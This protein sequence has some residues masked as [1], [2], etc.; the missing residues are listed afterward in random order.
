MTI[1]KIIGWILLVIGLAVI[2][3]TS[4]SSY[5]IF[6]ARAEAPEVFKMEEETPSQEDDKEISSQ[7]SPEELQKEMKK[8]VE[9]QI[10]EMIPSEFL[11][12]LLNLISWSIFT[13]ILIFAGGKITGIGI[14]L[15]K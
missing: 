7:P 13:G 1:R 2:F 12:K 8:I 10:K 6:T 15:I 3:W 9:E 4:Y 11:T 14:R 5:R